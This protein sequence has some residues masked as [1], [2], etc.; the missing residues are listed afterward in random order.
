MHLLPCG[1][2]VFLA[3]FSPIVGLFRAAVAFVAF[4][5]S[6]LVR[7]K[8]YDEGVEEAVALSESMASLCQALLLGRAC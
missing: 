8:A 2:V 1:E 4:L 3:V 7:K 5:P 6:A